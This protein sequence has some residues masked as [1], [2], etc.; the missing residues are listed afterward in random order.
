MTEACMGTVCSLVRI[1]CTVEGGRRWSG[2]D[3]SSRWAVAGIWGKRP[4]TAL[5]GMLMRRRA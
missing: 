3:A 4:Y 2:L 1:R 5:R